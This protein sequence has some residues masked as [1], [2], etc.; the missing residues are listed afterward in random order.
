[1]GVINADIKG[2]TWWRYRYDPFHFGTAKISFSHDF[3][4]IRSYDAIVYTDP[5]TRE[6]DSCRGMLFPDDPRFPL[7]AVR[8]RVL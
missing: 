8:A 6:W 3:D 5:R 7:D 4:V 1:M 2:R